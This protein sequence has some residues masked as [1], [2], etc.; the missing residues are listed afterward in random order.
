MPRLF[1]RRDLVFLGG[2]A[3]V[4]AIVMANDAWLT[5]RLEESAG[6]PGVTHLA[7]VSQPL[8]NP[9]VVLPVSLGLWQVGAHTGHA[10]LARRAFRVGACVMAAGTVTTGIKL[11]SGRSRPEDSPDD[12]Y[13]FDPF[14]G[15]DSFPSGHATIAFAAAVALDRET[16]AGWV[17]WVVY[18]AATLVAWSRVHD[19]KHWTS[20]VMVGSAIG[21]WAAWKTEDFL[22]SRALGVRDERRSSIQ[23]VPGAGGWMLVAQRRL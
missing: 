21:G 4:T 12:P 11:A 18:P 1:T 13:R 22:A 16:T 14:A 3:A 9:F 19:L 17:P 5:D 2:T 7:R 15:G 6:H 10:H 8:G 23:L 20:D